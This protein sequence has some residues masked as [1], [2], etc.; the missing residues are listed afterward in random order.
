VTWAKK[1]GKAQLRY[2]RLATFTHLSQF[3]NLNGVRQVAI[4]S[5]LAIANTHQYGWKLLKNFHGGAG[6]NPQRQKLSNM[7]RIQ[8]AL[9]DS[10]PAGFHI[11]QR[12]VRLTRLR[13]AK[14]VGS[15]PKRFFDEPEPLLE[16]Q[17]KIRV[18]RHLHPAIGAFHHG[19][20]GTGTAE[21]AGNAAFVFVKFSPTL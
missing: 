12:Q 5:K 19:T 3:A 4:E 15:R 11:P 13:R 9:N 18:T 21:A 7:V 16:T 1:L 10:F 17:N 2:W 6:Q 14:S 20:R 8:K